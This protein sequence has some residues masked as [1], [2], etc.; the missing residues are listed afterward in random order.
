MPAS[1]G[2]GQPGLAM[3]LLPGLGPFVSELM[4]VVGTDQR[5]AVAAV[6]V[7]SA[8]VRSTLYVLWTYQ[9]MFTG[10]TRS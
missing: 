3:L 5:Y 8:L 1:F 2:L 10:P 4:V 6:V 9:R 7:V